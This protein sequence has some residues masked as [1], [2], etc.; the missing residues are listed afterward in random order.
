MELTNDQ[1]DDLINLGYEL[2]IYDQSGVYP[3]GLN[4]DEWEEVERKKIL[5]NERVLIK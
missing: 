4:R 5:R 3:N 1:I 2:H